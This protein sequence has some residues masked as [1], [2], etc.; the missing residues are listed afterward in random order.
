MKRSILALSLLLVAS[1]VFGRDD[2]ERRE[3]REPEAGREPEQEEAPFQAPTRSF[4]AG[5]LVDLRFAYTDGTRG[6]LDRGLG[7][8]RYG[9]D[10]NGNRRAIFRLAQLSFIADAQ[11]FASLGAHLHLNLDAEPDRGSAADRLDLIEAFFRYRFEVGSEKELRGRVGLFFPPISLEHPGPA[12]TTVYTITPSVIN[13]W[14]GEEVRAGGAEVT[15]AHVGLENEISASASAFGW[16]DPGGSLVAYRGW[17]AHDRQTGFADR[18]PLAPIPAISPGGLFEGQAP[19]AEPIRENDHRAGYYVAASWERYQRLKVN[20]I[21]YDNRASPMVFDSE[22]YGWHTKFY[23]LGAVYSFTQ[24]SQGPELLFQYLDGNTWMG[25]LAPVLPKVHVDFRS[26]YVLF[27]LPVGR[28]RFSF[29]YDWFETVDL[30][31]LRNVDNNDETGSGF[32]LDY[33]YRVTEKQRLALE[34]LGVRSDRSARASLGLPA[35]A[36]ELLFQ[37]SYR[38]RF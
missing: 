15:Y 27:S 25:N 24:G 37:V 6:F 31:E 22:Q 9:G 3:K 29:R 23:D 20:G 11:L 1:A 18:I 33:Q 14:V 36:H 19:W 30:D 8:V 13:S 10:E 4:T 2:G 35:Q 32:T 12:W 7:K 26:A 38:L 16:N 17:A 34:L 5:V 21:Y 28:Q